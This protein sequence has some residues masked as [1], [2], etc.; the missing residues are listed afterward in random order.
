[1]KN[2]VFGNQ[3]VPSALA[4]PEIIRARFPALTREHNGKPVA[5]F[6]GPGGTQVPQDVVEAMVDY[7]YHHNANTHWNFPTSTE[8]DAALANAREA[9]A[10]FFN[11][12]PREVAFGNNM[13]TIT[14]HV[15]RG[16]GRAW[17]PGDEIVVT[18]LDHQANVAPWRALAKERGV[19]IRSVPFDVKTG[20]LVWSELERAVTSKTRLVAIGAASNALGTISSV[21]NAAQ[22]AHAKGALCF[23]DAVHF[24]AHRVIDV[25]AMECDFLACSPYKFY[26][27]HAGVLYARAEVMTW[28]DVPKL[29]PASNEIPERM[30]TGTQNHE[31]I[32]GGG[33]AVEFLASLASG[34]TRRERLVLAMSELHARGD[35][36]FAR[37]WSGLSEI[38]GVTCYGPPP[39]Q[40]RTPTVSFVVAGKPS[41]EVARALAQ[42][43]VFASNGNF[44]ATN[45][46]ERLGHTREGLV[47]AGCACYTTEGEVDR[48]IAGVRRIAS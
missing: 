4:A 19:T 33:A 15:A 30:E 27:P 36:L 22:L 35:A 32:V 46:L 17:G 23:V 7:L 21:R 13:T 44:Y 26:G 24:A 25:K 6:D 11:A 14:F 37:L 10:D 48:L 39:G 41:A 20:E 43:G 18:E 40:P 8:T 28:L 12:S 38:K 29:D 16:L 42:D 1:M 2:P 34:A 9:F 3:S 45:V 31:A 47:R 5:Y